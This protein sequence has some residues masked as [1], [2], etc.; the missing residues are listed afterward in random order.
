M[1]TYAYVV[2]FKLDVA[3]NTM[4]IVA[5]H[6]RPH[7]QY[8]ASLWS[9]PVSLME[10]ASE[11]GSRQNNTS[12]KK[13]FFL[14][15]KTSKFFKVHH[16]LTIN[17]SHSS[18]PKVSDFSRRKIPYTML[19]HLPNRRKFSL[20][21]FGSTSMDRLMEYLTSVLDFV[22]PDEDIGASMVDDELQDKSDEHCEQCCKFSALSE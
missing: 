18:K 8:S 3:Q 5:N 12:L 11:W 13:E 7:R 2:C 20:E 15:K 19:L 9:E 14:S 17:T 21:H 6:S 10:S 22:T 4:K 1:Y 16:L